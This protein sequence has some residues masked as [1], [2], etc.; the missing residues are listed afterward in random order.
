MREDGDV[1]VAEL[2]SRFVRQLAVIDSVVVLK[3]PLLI[4]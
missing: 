3:A 1:A 2:L 4:R